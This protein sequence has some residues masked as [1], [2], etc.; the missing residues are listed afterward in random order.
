MAERLIKRYPGVA[1]LWHYTA[2][3]YRIILDSNDADYLAEGIS[4]SR[5][6]QLDGLSVPELCAVAVCLRETKR[7]GYQEALVKQLAEDC[8]NDIFRFALRLVRKNH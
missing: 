1:R 7:A 2:D 3:D 6:K 8:L 5:M 4:N